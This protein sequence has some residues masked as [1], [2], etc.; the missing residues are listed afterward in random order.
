MTRRSA[1]ESGGRGSPGRAGSVALIAVAATATVVA[2]PPTHY[3]GLVPFMLAPV[4]F[5]VDG[6]RPWAGFGITWAYFSVVALTVSRWLTQALIDEYGVAP[7]SAWAFTVVFACAYSLIPAAGSWVYCALRGRVRLALAPMLFAALWALAEWVRS[8]PLGVPWVLVAHP[9]ADVP[10]ALQ[11]AD[12]CGVYGVSFLVATVNAGIGLAV[13]R[14]DPAPLVAALV[15]LVLVFGYGA[16]ALRQPEGDGPGVT[17][18]LVHSDVPPSKRF[19][20]GSMEE[21]ARRLIDRTRSSL[22]EADAR[23]VAWSET[24][25]D[26]DLSAKPA[27]LRELVALA[28]ELDATLITGAQ[29]TS[30]EGMY[31]SVFFLGPEAHEVSTYDKRR[32]VPFAEAEPPWIGRLVAPLLPGVEEGV[33]YRPGRRA[34]IV[35][36]NGWRL[37]ANVCFEITYTEHTRRLRAEGADLLLNL[38]ND[39]WF[40]AGGYADLHLQHAVF[41]AVELRTWVVR[42]ANAGVSAVIDPYGRVVRRLSPLESGEIVARVRA[43]GSPSPYARWGNGPVLAGLVLVPGLCLGLSAR[44]SPAGARVGIGRGAPRKRPRDPEGAAARPAARPPEA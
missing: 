13:R 39:G 9:L 43:A 19:V 1:R 27:L 38:S 32:L 26:G 21:N 5:L 8:E 25:I 3:T 20:S 30:P 23:I 34:T 42:N 18:A 36:R 29:R 33:P 14:R 4:V 41:R 40:A 24:A 35:E 11:I 44:R 2:L 22:R 7:G 6:R 16:V 17:V 10:I 31:N 37:G 28:A 15:T 12:L